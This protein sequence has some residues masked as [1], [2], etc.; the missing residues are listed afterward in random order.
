MTEIR[1]TRMPSRMQVVIGRGDTIMLKPTAVP[2]MR[3]FDEIVE[4]ARQQAR[5]A[6]M[7]RSDVAS[8]IAAVRSR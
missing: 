3:E 8:A 2:S 5:R 4:R 6:G 7:R 1:K